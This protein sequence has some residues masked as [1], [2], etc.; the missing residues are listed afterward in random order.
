MVLG[1]GNLSDCR[2]LQISPAANS[3]TLA[4]G[5][6]NVNN[7]NHHA[8]IMLL[9][10]EYFRRPSYQKETRIQLPSNLARRSSQ[11]RLS[12]EELSSLA[13]ATAAK[14][15]SLIFQFTLG[16]ASSNYNQL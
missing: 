7:L 8:S 10:T 4:K 16:S 11:L 2:F 3:S 9:S 12:F 15:E 5:E 13:T 14:F 6:A 1:I